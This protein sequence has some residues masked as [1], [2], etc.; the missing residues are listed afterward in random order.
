M[1]FAFR[2]A[3]FF[4]RSPVL[5]N[6][7]GKRRFM[8]CVLSLDDCNLLVV[9]V[10]AAADS[11]DRPL[12]DSLISKLTV[13]PKLRLFAARL[14]GLGVARREAIHSAVSD[15]GFTSIRI[16]GTNAPSVL[17]LGH[18]PPPW[19]VL[20]LGRRPPPRSVLGL[21]LR[22]PPISVLCFDLRPPSGLAVAP[23]MAALAD[24]PTPYSMTSL[25]RPTSPG[26]RLPWLMLP[27]G[28]L[29]CFPF[30]TPLP[31]APPF[32]SPAEALGDRGGAMGAVD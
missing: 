24:C 29:R 18:R 4:S 2:C 13:R 9:V 7:L 11:V 3:C 17:C 16:G 8:L 26:I 19:S 5:I 25:L 22:P 27:R 14:P 28:G 6:R 31:L 21:G 10:P 30:R 23:Y 12:S 15:G 20:C 1:C 32:V